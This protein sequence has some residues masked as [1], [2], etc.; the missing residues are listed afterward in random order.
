M[1]SDKAVWWDNTPIVYRGMEK[2]WRWRMTHK[3]F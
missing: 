3:D 2:S 1:G